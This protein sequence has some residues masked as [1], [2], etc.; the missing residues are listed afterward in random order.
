MNRTTQQD[1]TPTGDATQ[2]AADVV[3][4]DQNALAAR[5]RQSRARVDRAN[6][7]VARARE[8]LTTVVALAVSSRPQDADWWAHPGPLP[9]ERVIEAAG[10][11]TMGL[12]RL[13]ERYRT[14]IEKSG[15]RRGGRR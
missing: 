5:I 8:G 14:S 9:R 7:S 3:R 12:H 2:A 10:L 4:Q 13:M 6:A 11:T 1:R 15:R